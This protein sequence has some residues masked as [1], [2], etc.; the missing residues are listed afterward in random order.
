MTD[1]IRIMAEAKPWLSETA[2]AKLL[3]LALPPRS[4]RPR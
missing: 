3:A 1:T 2:G 4:I